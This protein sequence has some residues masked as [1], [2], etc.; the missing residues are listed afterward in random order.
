MPRPEIQPGCRLKLATPESPQVQRQSE[1]SSTL[2]DEQLLLLY[3]ESGSQEAFE[4]LVHRY[5]RKLY[6]YF[7]KRLGDEQLAEDAFQATFLQVHL[8]CRQFEVGRR[9]S[10]WLYQIA[11]KQAMDLLRRKRRS[12]VR[13]NNLAAPNEN[14]GKRP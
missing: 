11:A 7:R 9:L 10:P 8:T 5:E 4:E 13:L 12:Q 2:R 14:A 1:P 6:S 3:V